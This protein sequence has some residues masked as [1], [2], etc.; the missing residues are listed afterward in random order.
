LPYSWSELQQE[1]PQLTDFGQAR[2][3]G[4]VS[5]LATVQ[6]D[7]WP[8]IH[9]ITTVI[10]EGKCCFFAE[11]NS[12]KVGD[13]QDNG[14]FSLHCAMS[15]SSGSSGE[16]RL[17]GI[18][19]VI[20]DDELRA[21]IEAECSFRPSSTFLLFELTLAD[22]VATSYRRGRPDRSRWRETDAQSA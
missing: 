8:R 11:P 4:K 2:L 18:A 5:Y 20:D 12:A 13:L 22:V 6:P 21:R 1:V 15:D 14:R 10:A 7:G 9:P 17:G 19:K 3:D 16:F